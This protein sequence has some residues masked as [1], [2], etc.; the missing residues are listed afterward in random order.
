MVF[1]SV[2]PGRVLQDGGVNLNPNLEY[3]VNSVC[4]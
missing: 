1:V 3:E 2:F 4:Y